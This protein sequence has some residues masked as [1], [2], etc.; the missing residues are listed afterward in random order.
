MVEKKQRKLQRI[1]IKSFSIARGAFKFFTENLK[2][3]SLNVYIKL[4]I[5]LSGYFL[6]LNLLPAYGIEKKIS[7]QVM[8]ILKIFILERLDLHYLIKAQ[9]IFQINYSI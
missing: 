4:I 9:K 2:K 3:F 8:E 7:N 6:N 5:F 1:L